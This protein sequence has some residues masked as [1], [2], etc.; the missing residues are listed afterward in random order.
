MAVAQGAPTTWAQLN[1]NGY[2]DP[3]TNLMLMLAQNLARLPLV[4]SISYGGNEAAYGTSLLKVFDTTAQKVALTG[5]TILASSGDNGA[6]D[7]TCTNGY[8]PLFPAS[9]PWVT[10]VG[11]TQGVESG[12][13]EIVCQS[14]F[15]GVITGGGG[16]SVYAATPSWQTS[17]VSGYFTAAAAAGKSPAAG[18]KTGKRGYPDV[19]LAGANYQVTI[20]GKAATLCGTSASCPA[21]AGMISLIN[22]ARIAAGQPS[23]G[24]ANPA[25]YAAAKTAG[26]FNDITSGSNNCLAQSQQTTVTCCTQGYTA[27]AGW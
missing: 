23:V 2:S 26:V 14:Q 4:F 13:A 5:R 19:S 25:L 17:Q 18:Y 9:S 15:G 12:T 10:A 22:T 3:F 20:G 1:G 7:G 21:M 24:F 27:V 11:A 6:L 16:F 8:Q